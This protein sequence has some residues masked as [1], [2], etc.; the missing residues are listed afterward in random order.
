MKTKSTVNELYVEFLARR[1]SRLGTGSPY[2]RRNYEQRLRLFRERYGEM[3]VTHVTAAHVAEWIAEIA[4]RNLRPATLT[5][6]RQ[7]VKALFNY[8]VRKGEIRESPAAHLAAG[9]SISIQSK[10][11]PRTAVDHAT[12]LALRWLQSNNRLE[13]RDGLV[14]MLSRSCGPRRGEIIALRRRDV[15]AALQAGPDEHG[16]YQVGSSGKTGESIIRFNEVVAAGI[17]RWLAIRPDGPTDA[18]F[19]TGYKG[20]IRPLSP[21]SIDDSYR[22]VSAAAGLDRTIRSHALR[23]YVGDETTRRH[24][25][26]VAALLLNHADADTAATAIAYYHHPDLDDVSV[27]VAGLLS[28]VDEEAEMRKLFGLS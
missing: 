23:H 13:L 6:Y 17:H 7:A 14:F 24:G 12:S 1:P 11:P 16:I 27:A 25:A 15:I 19:V 22:R 18:L 4:K 8:A 26:K 2:N 10:K 3:A 21:R 20:P 9:S 28:A 5:G